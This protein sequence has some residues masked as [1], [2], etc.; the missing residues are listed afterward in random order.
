MAMVICTGVFHFEI[1]IE[2]RYQWTNEFSYIKTTSKANTLR[3]GTENQY[4]KL[5][6]ASIKKRERVCRETCLIK[7][8]TEK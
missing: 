7:P 4:Y 5:F 6:I 8:G 1:N 3:T 2:R